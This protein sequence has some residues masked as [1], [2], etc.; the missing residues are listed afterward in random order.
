MTPLDEK[1][2]E[3]LS[4][5]GEI[6]YNL[7]WSWTPEAR[8][9]FRRLDYPL[10][11]R[12]YH[13]PVRLLQEIGPDKLVE[14]AQDAT[15]LRQYNK[16]VIQYDEEMR[17]ENSW[18]HDTYTDLQDKTI[19]YFSFEFGLHNTLPIYSGGLGIL[20]GDHAKEASDLG[21]P[22]VGVGFMYPQ[23]YFR[24]R[25]PSHG[26]QE[27]VYEQL[28]MSKAP[29][30]PVLNGDGTELKVSVGLAGR[31]VYAKVWRV[32]VGRNPLFL[33]DTDVDE[34]DPWD[35]ELSA[36]LYSGDSETR[37]RQ[38]IMLGIG[39]VRMLRALNINPAVWHMNEGHSAFLTLECVR[40][41]VATG[42]TFEE[43]KTAVQKQS[44]FTTHTPV[45]AGH[46]AFNFHTVEKYFNGYWEKLGLSREEFLRLGGHEE[47]WGMAFNM[48]VLALR[49][50][51]KYNGVSKLHGQISRRMWQE[52]WPTKPVDEVPITSITNGIH[53]PTWVAGEMHYIF[54][55]Y[56]GPDWRQRHDDPVIWQRIA[57]V[58]DK[59][60]WEVHLA[61]KHK[62]MNFLRGR[63][64]WRWVD[65]TNDPTQVI[66]GGP[67]LDPEALTIGFAR[68]FATYKRADLI[69]RDLER[70]RHLLLDIHR[71]VQIIFAGKAHP[72]DDPG[73]TLIQ[74][75]YNLAKHNQLGGRVAFV[76]DYNMHTSRY[77]KQG[78]DVWLNT[79]RRP[80]EASGT[81]GMKTALNGVPNFSIL[82]GWW[83][84]GYNG[85]NG[86]TIGDESEFSDPNTQDE[87]DA[88]SLYQTLEDEIVPLFYK[89]DRDNVPRGWVEI[90][91]ESIR[92]CSPFFSTRR[93][94]K[95]Y[96]NELYVPAIKGN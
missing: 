19:A 91:R 8:G 86:W 87:H 1:L 6:A 46:D 32:Q 49:L 84:E 30:L 70:L 27:A 57:E 89:R 4:R 95:E 93:M 76:E 39:G 24:Q 51:G 50:S 62:L 81:S 65:G 79:P 96:T 22:F 2:P 34:N 54:D 12:T 18:F 60:L 85:G 15:F 36:R 3:K 66:T 90:M 75:I 33:M 92:T 17:H 7:W 20:S 23:G 68:R 37:I 13:N 25:I 53:V 48:T 43:A 28:D 40:E 41:K 71:P 5:L 77:L 64:R 42:M 67:L 56:L 73:K 80:R 94:V 9:L 31:S 82:D 21:L 16:V 83:V 59:E 47:E 38:E 26:W 58:P 61:L 63:V 14:A 10:W 72:A 44:I 55:K 29:V 88:N 35:R 11:R 74:H 52:V 45:P 69:F 78:V